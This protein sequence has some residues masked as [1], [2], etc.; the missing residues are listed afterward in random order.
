MGKVVSKKRLGR[1]VV[2]MEV[3]AGL[4]AGRAKPGQ[5]VIVRVDEKGER[6]PLTVYRQNTEKGTVELVF[7]EVGKTTLKLSRLNV[8]DEILDL[9]GPLGKPFQ[10]KLYG[11]VVVVG[12]GVGAA[13]AYPVAQALKKAGN[14]VTA[15]L[16]ARSADL[17]ILEEE[18]RNLVDEVYIA[19]DDGSRGRKGT[20]VDV[21]KDLIAQ[22]VEI[23]MV[24]AVGPAIMMKAVSEATKPYGVKTLVSL[25]PIML[26]GT[27]MCGSC[28]VSVGGETKL[29]C[30]DG[31]EFDGHQVD[32]EQL[33][34]RQRMYLEAEKKALQRFLEESA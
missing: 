18:F 3:E 19:T 14:H 26:D 29:T 24:Y 12:G 32:F 15:I 2:W 30:V 21:L 28:R 23:N 17:L 34:A 16:G 9:V 6:V 33:M 13:E 31:P 1:G 5:F 7:Q 27:G 11:S 10:E 25:N 20:V 4:V 8:G 22:R